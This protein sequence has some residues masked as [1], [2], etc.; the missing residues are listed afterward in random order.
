MLKPDDYINLIEEIRN[1]DIKSLDEYIEK[2]IVLRYLIG[3]TQ[4]GIFMKIEKN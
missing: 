2:V 4:K 3:A 1:T